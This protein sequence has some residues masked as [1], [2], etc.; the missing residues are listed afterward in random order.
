[1]LSFCANIG[2]YRAERFTPRSAIQR[3]IIFTLSC[4]LAH[5]KPFLQEKKNTKGNA[6]FEIRTYICYELYTTA[7]DIVQLRL[8]TSDIPFQITALVRISG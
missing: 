3:N 8:L 6:P 1:M 4:F 2:T 7:E 5:T